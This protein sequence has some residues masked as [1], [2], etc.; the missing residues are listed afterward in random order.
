MKHMAVGD[1]NGMYG[2]VNF[3]KSAKD[4]EV[5]PLI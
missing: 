4:F 5:N 2:A 3:F 1:Y